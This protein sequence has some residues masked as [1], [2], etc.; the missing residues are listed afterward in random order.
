MLLWNWLQHLLFKLRLLFS[1]ELFLDF[2]YFRV[3]KVAGQDALEDSKLLRHNSSP[4]ITLEDL[5]QLQI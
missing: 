5:L 4:L 3:A 2:D 1:E